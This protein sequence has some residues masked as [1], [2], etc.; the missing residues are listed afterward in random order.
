MAMYKEIKKESADT[1]TAFS[2][3]L[4]V[5]LFLLPLRPR[6]LLSVFKQAS[7]SRSFSPI[8]RKLLLVFDLPKYRNLYQSYFTRLFLS[9]LNWFSP[10]YPAECRAIASA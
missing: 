8:S 4:F 2:L 10:L 9:L 5:S 7:V 3:F 6:L 1:T